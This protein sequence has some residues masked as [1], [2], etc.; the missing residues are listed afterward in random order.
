MSLVWQ[1]ES[2][3][4]LSIASQKVGPTLLSFLPG[5]KLLPIQVIFSQC[6]FMHTPLRPLTQA[7]LSFKS[8]DSDATAPTEFA[9]LLG[10]FYNLADLCA[11]H[12]C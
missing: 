12:H 1:G 11:S 9:Q 4:S 5:K 6:I 7:Y 2:C 3:S 10:R 8:A